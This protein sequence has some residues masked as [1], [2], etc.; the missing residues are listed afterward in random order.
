MDI[1]LTGLPRSGTTLSCHLLNNLPA[2][3]A[4]HEPLD[5]RGLVKCAP[6][7]RLAWVEAAFADMR[8]QLLTAG[9]A[10]SKARAGII[11]D[12]QYEQIPGSDGVRRSLLTR[13][14]VHFDKPLAP[15]FKLVIK[16][17]NAFTALLPALARRFPCFALVRNPLAAILSWNSTG[18]PLGAGRA[19][20][21]EAF[22]PWLRR[23]LHAEP[24]LILRQVTILA[25]YYERYHSSLPAGS[26]VRYED[27]VD[28]DGRALAV[29]DPASRGLSQHLTNHNLNPSYDR[30]SVRPIAEV[31]LARD[32]SFWRY[33]SRGD[34]EELRDS[35]AAMG[36]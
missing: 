25:R 10:V 6:E 27:L 36:D 3:V 7:A 15:D 20:M 11:E 5:L 9:T 18:I 21:A 31:L 8:R 2:T 23:S 19:P 16:H 24:D 12:N 28:T 35:W 29:V 32:D 1:V 22:D 30:R 4:L 17:P 34:V 14:V 26:V 33:Y 13:Q